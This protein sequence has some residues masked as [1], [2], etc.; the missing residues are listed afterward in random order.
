[1]LSVFQNFTKRPVGFGIG[2]LYVTAVSY[3]NHAVAWRNQPV[4]VRGHPIPPVCGV[5]AGCCL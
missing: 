3:P 5:F 4:F 1:M 2:N